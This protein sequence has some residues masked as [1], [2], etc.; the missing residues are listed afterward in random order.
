MNTATSINMKAI[1][2]RVI[3]TMRKELHSALQDLANM[4]AGTRT[5]TGKPLGVCQQVWIEL[6]K[7]V[8][9]NGKVPSITDVRSMAKKHK[10]N[11]NNA[12]VECYRWRRAHSIHGRVAS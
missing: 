7:R 12:R 5:E 9:A 2:A 8:S 6:D 10:W 11:P 4:R 3:N 1:E